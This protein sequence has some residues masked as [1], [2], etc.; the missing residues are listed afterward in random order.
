MMKLIRN[1]EHL[2]DHSQGSG[3]RALVVS[4]MLLL[5]SNVFQ[6]SIFDSTSVLGW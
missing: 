3:K 2:H 5:R 6:D 4:E 1:V